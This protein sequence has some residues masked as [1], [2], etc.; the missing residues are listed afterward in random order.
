MDLCQSGEKD[1]EVITALKQ[2][3]DKTQQPEYF[4]TYHPFL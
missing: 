1:H 2:R 4:F 3:E